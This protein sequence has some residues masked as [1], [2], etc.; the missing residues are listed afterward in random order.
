MKALLANYSLG[1]EV[2]DRFKSKFRKQADGSHAVSIDLANVPSPPLVGP[3]WVKIR[4]ILSGI[5]SMEEGLLLRHDP[6][7]FAP[8][9]SFPFVPGNE[10]MGIV[11]DMGDKVQ[12][13]ELGQ[14]V[15]VNPLLSCLPRGITPLCPSCSS[16]HPSACRSF[17]K[18]AIGPGVAIGACADTGGG[19]GDEVLAHSSQ[20][21]PIPPSV[22]SE[23]AIL[24]PEFTRA[25]RAVLQFPPKPGDRVIVMGASSLGLLTLIALKRLGHNPHLIV[26]AEH[27]FEAD[28]VK[29][30]SDATVVMAH[31]AG[32]SYEEVA[33][34]VAGAV[35]YP[36]V[37]HLTLEG[38][39][40][41]VYETTGIQERMEDAVRF[42]G[43][44]KQ[45]V[46]MNPTQTLGFDM[47][48]LWL[49]GVGIEGTLF[50][51]AESYQGQTRE[52]FDIAI[53]LVEAAGLPLGDLM[54]HRFR[55]EDF[56][57]ALS[58]LADRAAS[59]AV[60]V[61]LTHVV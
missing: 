1:R 56:R 35:R 45:L 37:G 20:V 5:S 23:Q 57:Q 11:T 31:A 2:W 19:W 52:T 29:S 7:V 8:F 58:A 28:L 16:G 50:S 24:V 43:E 51:G 54:T 30:M 21:R 55:T 18:G 59:K 27:A 22:E 3:Q 26:V 14:R 60:K 46:L 42:T 53:D 40:D 47:A 12:G 36:E 49:K 61:V 48:P 17:A 6:S 41:L 4:S 9:L 15:V 34:L 44:R 25:V 38:G 10:I 13:I 39:A 33:A 32:S